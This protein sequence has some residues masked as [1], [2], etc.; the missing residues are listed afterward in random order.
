MNNPEENL[1]L[2]LQQNPDLKPYQMR[3]ENEM[4]QVPPEHRMAI[5]A[6]HMAWNLQELETE[7]TLLQHLLQKVAGEQYPK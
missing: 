6:K 5:V 1:R 3:L 7:L 4:N 2:F